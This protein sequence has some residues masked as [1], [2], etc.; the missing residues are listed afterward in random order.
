M[1]RDHDATAQPERP[2]ICPHAATRNVHTA[3]RFTSK[4]V[5][6]AASSALTGEKSTTSTTESP[7][8]NVSQ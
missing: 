6:E 3:G 2:G 8:P 1:L 4:T 5:S 7:D